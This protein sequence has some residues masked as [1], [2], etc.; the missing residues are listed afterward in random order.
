MHTI[1]AGTLRRQLTEVYRA[2]GMP[3]ENITVIVENM[4]ESDLRGID[5]H[6]VGMLPRYDGQR[7][8]G[9]LNMTPDVRVVRDFGAVALIDADHGLGHVAGT[10]A[11]QMACDKAEQFGVGAV[12]ARGS[13]HFGAAGVYSTMAVDRGLIGLCTTGTTQRSVLPTFAKEL[14]GDR[15]SEEEWFQEQQELMEEQVAGRFRGEMTCNYRAAAY[16]EA[17]RAKAGAKLKFARRHRV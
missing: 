7:K 5:S 10:K 4:V 16:A 17:G 12:T 8:D 9:A 2:W 3:D 11:M 15:V 6:G 1:Q 13:N 14:K